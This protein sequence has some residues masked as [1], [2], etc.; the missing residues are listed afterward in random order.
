M[1]SQNGFECA[2]NTPIEGIIWQKRIEGSMV[3]KGDNCS[4]PPDFKVKT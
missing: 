2:K 1:F 3:A 4:G